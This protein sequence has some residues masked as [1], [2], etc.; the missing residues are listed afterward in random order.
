[1]SYPSI[2]HF[3]SP[4]SIEFTTKEG[5]K[6][7]LTTPHQIFENRKTFNHPDRFIEI[8]QSYHVDDISNNK[9][10]VIDEPCQALCAIFRNAAI[11]KRI[12]RP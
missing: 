9:R 5:G 6:D 12:E 10:I 1:M 8:I 4:T 2:L 7:Y 3:S 11:E